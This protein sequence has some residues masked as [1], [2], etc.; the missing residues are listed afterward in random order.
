MNIDLHSSK[1]L[2]RDKLIMIKLIEFYND[3]QHLKT[4]IDIVSGNAEI[5]LRDVDWFVT[6]YSKKNNIIY[7]VT[8]NDI[9]KQFMVFTNYKSQLKGFGKVFFDPFCRNKRINFTFETSKSL[10]TTVGQLNFFKWAISND[11]IDY[12]NNHL[13]EIKKDMNASTKHLKN[14]NKIEPNIRRKRTTLSVSANRTVNRHVVPVVMDFSG[15]DKGN[16]SNK[17]SKTIEKLSHKVEDES[18]NPYFN[19]YIA[20]CHQ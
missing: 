19:R 3:K 2:G 13:S 9:T 8:D 5:S 14:S 12:I 15:N 17:V 4:L 16:L 1:P 7:N 18:V 6:N 20:V 10:V 11:I